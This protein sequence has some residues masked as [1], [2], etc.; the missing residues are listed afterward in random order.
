MTEPGLRSASELAQSIRSR[1]LSAVELLDHYLDRV[2]RLN[3]AINALVTFDRNGAR[4]RALAADRA[5]TAGGQLPPL[6]GLPCTIKDAIATAGLRTTGGA[7]ELS[8]NVPTVDATV[9]ERLR[10]AGANIFAKSNLPRW[11][12]DMQAFNEIFGTTNNPW[13][14]T[15]G[16]GGSS[17]GAAAAVA[18]GM[19]SF[20]IGTDIGGSIRGPAHLCGICGHKPSF[21]LVPALGY[22]DHVTAGLTEPDINVLGPLARTVDD[23]TLLLDVIAGPT[24]DRALAWR[25]ELPGPRA[26]RLADLRIAAW[27]D[28]P[29]CPVS[30][31]VAAVLD[32][33]VA[34]LTTAGA[35]VDRSARPGFNPEVVRRVG[36][37]LISA[38]TSPGR[39]D[40]EFDQFRRIA[41][42]P[43]GHEPT[44]VMRAR[45]S[46]AHHRD[47]LLATEER[48]RVRRSWAE[49]FTRFDVLLCPVLIVPAFEHQHEG[50]LY[51]RVLTVDGGERPYADLIWWTALIGMAYLP[52]TVVPVGSTPTGLPVGVQVVGP[53]LEDRTALSAARHLERLRGGYCPPPMALVD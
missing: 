44:L 31:D 6:H 53:F 34:D 39:T 43:E 42:E 4:V 21:G 29:T 22:I 27:L 38:A 47:W 5:T 10:R 23:L 24:P 41:A 11:S 52:S 32:D 48:E 37:P 30:S 50:T 51:T 36:L 13:D 12:G 14:L 46:A 40:A 9:V 17:G 20:D 8:S 3:P 26:S 2:D 35:S 16:P 19:T 15:R 28:D 7:T 18:A 33:L 45:A 49:F 1:E 25:L